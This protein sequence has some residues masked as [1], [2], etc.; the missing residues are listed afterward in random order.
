MCFCRFISEIL[1]KFAYHLSQYVSAFNNSRT[2][3]RIFMK[4]Y[5]LQFVESEALTEATVQTSI[6]KD[7]TSRNPVELHLC[8][9]EA[10]VGF[11]CTAVTYIYIWKFH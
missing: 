2:D 5:I 10:S 3:E 1:K 11:Y 4:C 6:F 8:S 9:F 7:V